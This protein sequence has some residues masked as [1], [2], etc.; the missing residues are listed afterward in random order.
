MY[1]VGSCGRWQTMDGAIKAW[2]PGALGASVLGASFAAG[3]QPSSGVY[4]PAQANA[5]R[6]AYESRC[7]VCH[8]SHFKGSNE[9]P[10][11]AGANFM[12]PWRELKVSDLFNRIRNAMP[13]N[14]PGSL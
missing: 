4:T 1:G 2:G 11:L 3:Q 5:G 8:G 6:S 14:N 7:A 13:A 9:A 10:A 12:D